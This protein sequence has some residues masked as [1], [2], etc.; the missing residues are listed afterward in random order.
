MKFNEAARAALYATTPLAVAIGV[1]T[2]VWGHA[3]VAKVEL[4]ILSVLIPLH[5]L[6]FRRRWVALLSGKE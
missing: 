1:A 3:Q 2:E 4:A 6:V 5:L